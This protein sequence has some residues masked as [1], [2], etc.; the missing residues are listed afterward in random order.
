[1]PF[2]EKLTATRQA[3]PKPEI[4]LTPLDTSIVE[5]AVLKATG[6]AADSSGPYTGRRYLLAGTILSKRTDGLYERYIAG[7]GQNE[8]QRLVVAAT[9]GTFTLTYSGQTTS[10]LAY[11]AN[12]AAVQAALEALSNLA[13]ADVVV[14]GGPGDSDGSTPYVLTFGGTLAETDVALITTNSGSLTGGA[15][16][17][18]VTTTTPGTSTD[19][20]IA[21]IL[22][23]T[24]EFASGQDTS[25][26]PAAFLRRNV[27]FDKTKI[28]D[29]ATYQSALATWA[30]ANNNEFN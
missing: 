10:A 1:M 15:H 5:S 27:N 12:A 14:S 9:G 28:V 2:N 13:P 24:V 23:D 11:N 22:F 29:Y 30:T 26:E 4:L 21:G 17:A 20:A 16:S 25:N 8:V 18:T 19:Q 6:V 7:T 3:L